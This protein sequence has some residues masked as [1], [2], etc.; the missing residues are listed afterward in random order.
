MSGTDVRAADDR[1]RRAY[2]PTVVLA[3]L[4]AVLLVLAANK[5]L[6]IAPDVPADRYAGRGEVPLAGG[7]AVLPLIAWAAILVLRGQARRV[8]ALVALTGFVG[9]LAAADAGM[10]GAADAVSEAVAALSATGQVQTQFSTWFWVLAVSAVI[11]SLMSGVALRHAASW[12]SMSKRY[13][14]AGAA[15][16]P[17]GDGSSRD[18][19]RAMDEGRDPTAT[20][21]ERDN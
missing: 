1:G 10:D 11:G 13:D 15:E 12:P 19:W 7:L 4:A 17:A 6:V 5:Q 8:A 20:D 3:V 16:E 21:T 18:L 2:V 14:A 9:S